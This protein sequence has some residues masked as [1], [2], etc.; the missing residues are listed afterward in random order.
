[1]ATTTPT[2]PAAQGP[3]PHPTPV[4]RA[5]TT[6]ALIAKVLGLGLVL[7]LAIAISPTLIGQSRWGFLAIVWAIAVLALATYAGRRALP[8]KYILPGTL[9]LLLFVIYPVVMTAKASTTNFGDGTRQSKEETIAQIVASSVVQSPDAPR[10][11][12]TVATEGSVTEGPF[13][14]FLVSQQDQSLYKGTVDG[15][16]PIAAGD[17]TVTN[18]AVTAAPGYTILTPQQVNAANATIKDLAVPT[19]TGAIRPLGIRQAFEGTTTLRY[20][21]ATDTITDTRDGTQYTPVTSGDREFFTSADG[22]RV[23][24]QSWLANVGLDNYQRALTDSTIRQ[25]FIRI[26]IWTV[27]FATL[28]VGTTFLVGLLLATTLNDSRMKGQRLYRSLLLL[29]YAMP[30]FISLLVWSGFFNKDF[31]LINSLT[32]LDIGWFTSTFWARTAVVLTNLWM[33]F[34]YMFIVCTGALQAIPSDLKEAAAIDGAS[35]FTQFRKITFP[36][37]LVTVAPLLVASF[38]FNFNNFN[39][40]ALLTEGAPFA[41]DNP[42]AGGTDILIS[43]TIR[44]A[45]GAG[46]AQLGF[47]S[48]ISVL[49]FVLTGV[50]AAIQFRATRTLEDV[51]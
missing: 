23:S 18:N 10:Y 29:P 25:D 9:L 37:L 17:V 14:L 47:A 3:D 1:M 34:P 5:G 8:A 24:D 22:R 41:P 13:T 44:L 21:E 11:T 48:A 40:I 38:A 42:E 27:L 15:L 26:F 20:D 45:F 49:L 35:G 31:G 33:G 46:G 30:G 36:L 32:G 6:T 39:A 50:I 7:G 4:R 28:S 19:E 12:M 2:R 51:N 16:E 43:Y